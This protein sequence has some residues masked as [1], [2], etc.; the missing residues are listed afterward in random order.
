L[1]SSEMH[2]EA[3]DPWVEQNRWVWAWSNG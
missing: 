2:I 3:W 1:Q